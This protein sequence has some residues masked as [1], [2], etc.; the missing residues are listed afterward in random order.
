MLSAVLYVLYEQLIGK[1]IDYGIDGGS[2][3]SELLVFA[4]VCFIFVW[5]GFTLVARAHPIPDRHHELRYVL[6]FGAL[7]M[8]GV[9]SGTVTFAIESSL[10]GKEYSFAEHLTVPLLTIG[11]MLIGLCWLAA[12]PGPSP[13]TYLLL[14]PLG[15]SF[16]HDILAGNGPDAVWGALSTLFRLAGSLCAFATWLAAAVLLSRMRS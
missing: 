8:A 11:S 9:L 2:K 16:V 6:T 13:L 1:A 14:L 12:R 4:A 5:L 15:I 10:M 3:P 7:A